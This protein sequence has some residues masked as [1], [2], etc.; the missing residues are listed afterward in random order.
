MCI[1]IALTACCV[2]LI[3]SNMLID[4]K[5]DQSAIKSG[6]RINNE[7][8]SVPISRTSLTR[9]GTTRSPRVASARDPQTTRA[10]SRGLIPS[11]DSVSNPIRF[12]VIGPLTNCL[13]CASIDWVQPRSLDFSYPRGGTNLQKLTR[14]PF[15][16]F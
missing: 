8:P 10:I 5:S 16:Q 3:R 6:V 13:H 9:D 2:L 1:C 11:D 7:G 14:L 12:V 4:I 15:P